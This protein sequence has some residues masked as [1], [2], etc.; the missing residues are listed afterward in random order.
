VDADFSGMRVLLYDQALRSD[1]GNSRKSWVRRGL[2]QSRSHVVARLTRAKGSGRAH[3]STCTDTS[4]DYAR[5]NM[6]AREH[7]LGEGWNGCRMGISTGE[8]AGV[9]GTRTSLVEDELKLSGMHT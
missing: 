5:L 1:T 6:C 3:D 2:R 8:L 4:H 9:G 7:M